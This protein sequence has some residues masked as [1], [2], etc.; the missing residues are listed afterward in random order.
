MRPAASSRCDLPLA[1]NTKARL[2][3][4]WKRGCFSLDCFAAYNNVISGLLRFAR[5]DDH[6]RTSLRG[7]AEA[8][9]KNHLFSFKYICKL[10]NDGYLCSRKQHSNNNF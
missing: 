3:E 9:R 4:G 7:E 5:N 1:S 2:G 8:I 6:A 10:K